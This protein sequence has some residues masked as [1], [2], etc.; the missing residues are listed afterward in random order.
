MLS[1]RRTS[2]RGHT[3]Q[4]IQIQRDTRKSSQN[5]PIVL[6]PFAHGNYLADMRGVMFFCLPSLLDVLLDTVANSF[7]YQ[8]DI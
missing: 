5:Q 1:S 4:A 8:Q 2:L 6:D 7:S 3:L